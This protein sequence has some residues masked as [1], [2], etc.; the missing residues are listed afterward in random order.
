MSS[1]LRE[2]G[3]LKSSMPST[4]STSLLT[5]FRKVICAT[6]KQVPRLVAPKSITASILNG[7]W[8][9]G[10]RD[11]REAAELLEQTR[12]QPSVRYARLL[13]PFGSLRRQ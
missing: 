11:A 8:R 12:A 1:C 10:T 3:A 7:G 4:P 13:W 9:G 5:V 2:C 6:Q